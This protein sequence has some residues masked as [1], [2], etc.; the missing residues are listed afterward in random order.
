MNALSELGGNTRAHTHTHICAHIAVQIRMG[1]QLFS[2]GGWQRGQR[3]TVY[4]Y[5][6]W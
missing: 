3:V 4:D 6:S 1:Y 2:P 5:P